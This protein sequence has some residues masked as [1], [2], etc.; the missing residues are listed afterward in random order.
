MKPY[1]LITPVLN[2]A[3]IGMMIASICGVDKVGNIAVTVEMT[4]NIIGAAMLTLLNP[5]MFL[6]QAIVKAEHFENDLSKVVKGKVSHSNRARRWFTGIQ[7]VV[8][9]T[10]MLWTDNTAVGV[11]VIVNMF[12]SAFMNSMADNYNEKL[13]KIKRELELKCE[14]KGEID[15]ADSGN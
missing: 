13:D 7:N 6:A 10:L 12:G 3:V 15:N 2:F 9:V 1:K 8:I 14:S 5:F 4:L 11:L